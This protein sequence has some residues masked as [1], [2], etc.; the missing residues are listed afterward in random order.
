MAIEE[1]EIYQ[2]PIRARSF[3]RTLI[4]LSEQS[5]TQIL[6][7]T[8]S[9]YFMQPE[10]FAAL[11]RFTYRGGETFVASAT[12]QS[13]ATDSGIDED[14]VEKAITSHIPTEFSEG[15]F[16]DGVALVE[17]PTDRVVIDAVA[18]K[19]GFDLDHNGITVLS[20]EGKG[21][22]RVARAILT[23][24][25]IPTY[26]LADGDHGTSDNKT[27]K[28]P[29]AAHE[30]HK[31]DTERLVS[32]LPTTSEVKQ[33]SLPYNFGDPTVVCTGFT[34]WKDDIEAELGSWSTFVAALSADGIDL[35][36][37]S[38]KNL[39]AYRNA[40][41]SATDNDIPEVLRTVIEAIIGVAHSSGSEADQQVKEV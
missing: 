27:Y 8:H 26:V 5:G 37:R 23:A 40:V 1:P 6:L 28:D 36:A 22:L 30:S 14:K 39:L 16:A 2:H 19:L 34:I 10:Q 3:A 18:A 24:L 17:G 32:A 4:E 11:H 25:G 33:G 29:A 35:A 31:A 12:V 9:P 38:N 20:V 21:G 7:A 15:F 41:I 13:V